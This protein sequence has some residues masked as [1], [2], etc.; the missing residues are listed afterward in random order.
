MRIGFFHNAPYYLRSYT[1]TLTALLERG[2][3]LL[4]ARPDRYE[5]VWVPASLRKNRRVSTGLYP[6]SRGDGLDEPLR[7]VRAG[8]DFVRYN[9]PPLSEAHANRARAFERLLRSVIGKGRSLAHEGSVPTFEVEEAERAALDRLFA[10]LERLIPPDEGIRGF[11]REHRLDLVLC[12]SRINFAARQTEVIKAAKSLGLPTG[13]VVYSWDNLSSKG[14]VHE[15]PDRLFVWNELQAGEAERL[16]GIDRR[17]VAVTGAVRF[18]PVFDSVPSAGRDELRGEL[19]LD[20][21][22]TTLLW[23][24][25]SAFV[26]PC[27]PDFVTEW[28]AALR[29]SGDERIREAN[30]IVRPH[31]GTADDPVWTS[32]MPP[33]ARVV[34]P[35]AVVRK[36][37]QDLFDQLS[38]SDA[39]VS[40]NTSAEIEA[41][42]V[43]RPVLTVRAGELAPGQIGTVHFGY[44]L[45]EEGGFVVSAETLDEHLVQLGRAL[46]GDTH[47]DA[48]RRFLEGFVRPAGIDKPAAGVLADAIEELGGTGSARPH[49]LGR[50]LKL[51]VRRNA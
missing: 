2:H 12:I 21:G 9:A 47:A 7:I 6:Y 3:R 44:L 18:D 39:V 51:A 15:H 4:L 10:D 14:L 1:P 24:G 23:L 37:A 48:R 38:A 50:R 26:S 19:G 30:V 34:V 41:A 27:E 16:H 11:I 46:A 25:S 29:A 45:A 43:G 20:A 40:L 8:R 13:L 17:Q 36:R 49:D 42:I 5:D 31:P 32:W 33:D 35:P 22:R 28:V